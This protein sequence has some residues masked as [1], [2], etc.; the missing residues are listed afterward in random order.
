MDS[1]ATDAYY[2]CNLNRNEAARVLEEPA[3]LWSAAEADA[4]VAHRSVDEYMRSVNKQADSFMR[5]ESLHDREG[6]RDQLRYLFN[7]EQG[8]GTLALVLGS[9]SVGKTFLMRKLVEELHDAGRRFDSRQ[10]SLLAEAQQIE[11]SVGAATTAE[12]TA[13]RDR[14]SA[15]R[16]LAVA[17][18]EQL[19]SRVV[20]YNA[21]GASGDLASGL[22]EA[23]VQDTPLYKRFLSALALGAE[24]GTQVF[25][26]LQTGSAAGGK[27]VGA[28]AAALV[29]ML[30]KKQLTL[31]QMLAAY[32]EACAAEQRYPCLVVEETNRAL[33]DVDPEA[34]ERSL[35]A[36]N[37]LTQF[38]KEERRMNVVLTA[39]E[40]SEP[41]RLHELGF[42]SDHW[43]GIVAVGEVP[44]APMRDLL[45]NKW[46]VGEHLAD[47]IMSVWGG[48]VWGI[49]K[50][51]GLLTADRERFA[52]IDN[53]VLFSF[54]ATRGASFCV[55]A[56]DEEE[57]L[58][59]AAEVTHPQLL[60]M[61]NLLTKA[62]TQGW[63]PFVA[64]QDPRVALA[65]KRNVLSVVMRQARAPH[66]RPTA[67]K[68][69]RQVAVPSSQAMRLLLALELRDY[70]AS[71]RS[72]DPYR[73]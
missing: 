52:A 59:T 43:T 56:E 44:P 61:R 30:N 33:R 37:L 50:G 67:F 42:K 31:K 64:E 38:T 2:S 41:F 51:L 72:A 58:H 35:D 14:A 66:V 17:E 40:F 5:S 19:P 21:R 36:L 70:R 16:R 45:R 69:T 28:A 65:T 60:G 47:A 12:A 26:E 63:A 6:A 10:I 54:D 32:V 68:G 18:L 48:H 8:K 57:A 49:Y 46:G 11:D 71:L 15:L 53:P 27:A 24:K 23:L 62:A 22:L 3:F 25:V 4:A 7:G 1:T 29:E 39:S 73:D 20:V 13:A 9:K 34:R 55:R